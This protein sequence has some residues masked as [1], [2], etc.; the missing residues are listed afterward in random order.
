MSK[1][2][3]FRNYKVVRPEWV[4]DSVRVG[5][6]L[7][8][9]KYRLI[10][11]GNIGASI[12]AL[13]DPL[14]QLSA[15]PARQG[16]ESG[17][18]GLL[19]KPTLVIDRF[20]EGL[21]RSWVR[22]NLASDKDFIK[23]YYKNSRLHHL[24]TWKAE[25]KDYVAQLRSKYRKGKGTD[26]KVDRGNR[27]IMHVDFD[28]FFVTASLLSHPYL[29]DKPVAVCHSQQQQQQ[30]VD[31]DQIDEE[32]LRAMSRLGGT[33]QIA[34]CNYTARSFGVRN[35]MFL[36]PAREKCP[37]LMT[38][39]YYFDTYKRISRRFYEELTRIADEIQAVSIDEALLD[40]T[41]AVHHGFGGSPERLAHHIRQIIYEQTQC[42]VSI[43][44]GPNILLARV[45]TN[46]AKPDGVFTIAADQF[47]TIDLKVRDL[48]GIGYTLEKD[49]VQHNI[50][51]VRDVRN[52]TLAELQAICGEKTGQALYEHSRG[53]D[54][55]VLESDK[56]RQAFGADIGWGWS[57]K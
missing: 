44:I 6:Q 38:V 45:A 54:N 43:G 12:N 19:V 21:N 13:S 4:V 15:Q 37:G 14:S 35:G 56:L 47:D 18:L 24:S 25:M 50:A 20:N 9:H 33:S 41:E 30:P 36:G 26:K 17:N 7:P 32:S 52:A 42:V 27:I 51:S 23:R 16:S 49:L 46:K 22:K 55:R 48:P 5:K 3:E 40:V 57:A 10:G 31:S 34:S 39:P 28:C 2:K 1:E 29:K 11:Q 8:W 53:I